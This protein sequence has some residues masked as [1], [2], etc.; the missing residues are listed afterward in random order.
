MSANDIIAN[1]EAAVIAAALPALQNID[2]AVKA[3]AAAPGNAAVFVQQEA[4][5]ISNVNT[6]V[7]EA[8]ALIP[9]LQGQAIAAAATQ[10]GDLLDKL[11]ADLQAKIAAAKA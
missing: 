3:I 8:P 2:A 5:I 9:V 4:V 10:A 7:L 11:I 6:L 1:L